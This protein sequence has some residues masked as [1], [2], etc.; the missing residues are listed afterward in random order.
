MLCSSSSAQC[1]LNKTFGCAF[2]VPH[3][4]CSNPRSGVWTG[5]GCSGWFT[6][7]SR[8]LKCKQNSE[9][10]FDDPILHAPPSNPMPKNK[11]CLVLFTC[12]RSSWY[13]ANRKDRR[14]ANLNEVYRDRVPQWLA[15]GM[16]TFSV[17]SCASMSA[18]VGGFS[19]P[20]VTPLN[21][22]G[23]TSHCVWGCPTVREKAALA[24]V[25][26]HLPPQCEFVFKITGKYFAP[27]FDAEFARVPADA[28]AVV[29][30]DVFTYGKAMKTPYPLSQQSEIYGIRR[31]L[32]AELL[33]E[34][35]R[36]AESQ[37]RRFTM[38]RCER[39]HR[40][41]RLPLVN[42]TMRSDW[43]MLSFLR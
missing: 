27:S 30:Y 2:T 40:M 10:W 31:P 16:Q 28:E 22:N 3:D 41:N 21:F 43:R 17:D 18:Q 1:A 24:H 7:G 33:K 29:Q 5:S 38:R 4:P 13:E 36:D 35:G 23:S 11:V 20:G 8:R 14:F 25:D 39:V 37:L 15:F 9:C 32:I 12:S 42:F 6:V 34:R 26:R 19:T